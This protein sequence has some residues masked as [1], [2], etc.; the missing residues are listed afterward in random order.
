MIPLT[1]A[2]KTVRCLGMNLAKE[3]KDLYSENYRTLLKEME[4]NTKKCKSIPCSWNRRTNIVK[5]SSLPKVIYTF[6]VIPLKIPPAFFRA[7]F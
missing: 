5:I 3:V 2:P 7:R 4:D 1:I 6:N